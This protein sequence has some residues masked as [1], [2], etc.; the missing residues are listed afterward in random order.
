MSDGF[1]EGHEEIAHE[2]IKEQQ[3]EIK[4]RMDP[5]DSEEFM[6]TMYD[7]HKYTA[8]PALKHLSNKIEEID[9]NWVFGNYETK[10]ETIIQMLEGLLDDVDFLLPN[11]PN[12]VIKTAFLREIFSRITLTRGRKGFAAKLFVTQIGTTKAEI[13]GLDKNKA[14]FLNI[15]RRG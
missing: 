14:K 9:K 12:S 10:D 11:K 5:H 1:N 15:K 4:E 8:N 7:F 2:I 13:T 3:K 6:E